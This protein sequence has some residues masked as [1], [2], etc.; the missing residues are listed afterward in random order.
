[1]WFCSS[2][3]QKTQNKH[4]WCCFPNRNIRNQGSS[5]LVESFVCLEQFTL[6]KSHLIILGICGYVNATFYHSLL[7]TNYWEYQYHLIF[8]LWNF[9]VM[10]LCDFATEALSQG[11]LAM[12][13]AVSHSTAVHSFVLTETHWFLAQ[14]NLPFSTSVP[15]PRNDCVCTEVLAEIE[16]SSSPQ[17]V[18]P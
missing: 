11:E 1:M 2:S 3:F 16:V 13:P 6:Q 17:W 14:S 12:C 7:V 18:I 9:C 10:N 8:F 15:I 4:W 5:Q